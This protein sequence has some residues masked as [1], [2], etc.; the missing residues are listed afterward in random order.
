MPRKRILLEAVEQHPICALMHCN[1]ACYDS[2]LG[3]LEVAKARLQLALKL[4]R[5]MRLMALDDEDLRPLR[6]EIG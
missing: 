6:D 4:D 1:L 5:G 2:V 3:E